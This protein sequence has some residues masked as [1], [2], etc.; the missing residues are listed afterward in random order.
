MLK[1]SM[2]A[3]VLCLAALPVLAQQDSSQQSTGDPVADAARKARAQKKDE[4]KPKRVFTD[5]DVKP[6]QPAPPTPTPTTGKDAAADATKKNGA[7]GKEGASDGDAK[8]DK[9]SEQAWRKRFQSQRD[10]IATAEKELSVLQRESE[11]SQ[12]QYYPDPQKALIQQNTR[13]DINELNQKIADKQAEIAKL[14]QGLEDLTDALRKA[15][16]D[17]GWAR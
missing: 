1:I 2:L 10:N 7:G 13:Q 6:A 5:D 8:V 9:N 17:S 16:G 11:K 12:V 3:P 4:A 15:G 14:K